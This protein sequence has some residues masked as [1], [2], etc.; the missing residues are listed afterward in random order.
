MILDGNCFSHSVSLATFHSYPVLCPSF[1]SVRVCV[2][3][4]LFSI[5]SNCFC[6]HT[7]R[8]DEIVTNSAAVPARLQAKGGR[9]KNNS[10]KREQHIICCVRCTAHSLLARLKVKHAV[11]QQRFK[12][13]VKKMGKQASNAR[14][15]AL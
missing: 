10:L 2:C 13:R 9:K 12:G 3:V 14:L 15:S 5:N 11:H 6:E 4:C 8:I 7:N 1:H